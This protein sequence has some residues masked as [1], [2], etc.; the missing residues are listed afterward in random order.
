MNNSKQCPNIPSTK[1]ATLRELL[2][3]GEQQAAD[4]GAF[5]D[6]SLDKILR[7]IDE[8]PANLTK[9]NNVTYP[10]N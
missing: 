6:Y 4:S 1:L 2:A 5:A 7:L 10:G 9:K 8:Q 3:Q